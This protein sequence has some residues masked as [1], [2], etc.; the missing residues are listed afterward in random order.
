MNW[1]RPAAR[2][3]AAA[4]RAVPAATPDDALPWRLVDDGLRLELRVQPGAKA[5]RVEGV[6][7][8]A[9]GTAVLKLRVTAPPEGGKANAA[10]VKLLAKRWKLAKSDI[11]VIAGETARRKS[12]LL[13]GDPTSLG[14]TLASDLR[15]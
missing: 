4:S 13:R 9:D 11:A 3:W 1:W 15:G 2:G 14:R 10:V 12:L 8:L 6:E 5:D 7:T